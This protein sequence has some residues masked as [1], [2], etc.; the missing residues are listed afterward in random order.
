MHAFEITGAVREKGDKRYLKVDALRV[1]SEEG[2][3]PEKAEAPSPQPPFEAP[4]ITLKD[5]AGAEQ[6][7]SAYRGESIVVVNFWATWCVPC[8][9]EMPVLVS[10]QKRYKARGVQ[11]IGISADDE[12]TRGQIPAFVKKA[13]INFPIWV[14]ATTREMRSLQ[15]GDDLPATAIIDRDGLVVGRIIGMVEKGDL[16][17]RIEWLLSDRSAPAPAPLVDNTAGH[18]GHEHAEGEHTHGEPGKAST[19]PN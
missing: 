10:L 3:G 11:V 9:E 13:K 18:E 6:R 15:L 1:I 2:K 4:E 19:V 12:S 7:L 17:D 16:E 14:G 8:R 5:M